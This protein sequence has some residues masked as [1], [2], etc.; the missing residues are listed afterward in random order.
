MTFKKDIEEGNKEDR[1]VEIDDY[2]IKYYHNVESSTGSW[3]WKVHPNTGKTTSNP[4]ISKIESDD[5]LLI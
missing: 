2:F 3:W 4:V 1:I 5:N